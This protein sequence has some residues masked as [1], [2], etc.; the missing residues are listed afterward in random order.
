MTNPDDSEHVGVQNAPFVANDG[1]SP[2][3]AYYGT[4]MV[5]LWDGNEKFGPYSALDINPPHSFT[6]SAFHRSV[7][8]CGSCH[9][10]SNPSVGDLAHNN[11]TLDGAPA[12]VSSGV[13]GSPVE[14][15]AAFNN[16][17]HQYGVTERTFSEYKS[18]A[19]VQTRVSD[20][21]TLP[22]ELQAGAILEA[23]TAAQAAG[24]GGDYE[25]G[26]PRYFSCQTCHMQP[27]TGIGCDKNGVPIRA[28]SA[29]S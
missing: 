28:G 8:F 3:N 4:G 14:G 25:D 7:D 20:F 18:G 15:K 21:L 19:L 22:P 11:G 27:T 5:S 23:Y 2:A 16:F 10:V 26:T 6:A 1:G 9:D 12:V 13:P 29:A 24:T 17:P